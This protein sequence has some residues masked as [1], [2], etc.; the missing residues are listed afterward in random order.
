MG[1]YLA[2]HEPDTIVC[3]EAISS[4][5]DEGGTGQ[6]LHRN[7]KRF[8]LNLL[9]LT[10]FPHYT[11]SLQSPRN[12][13]SSVKNN[14]NV[15]QRSRHGPYIGT[16][17]PRKCRSR[18]VDPVLCIRGTQACSTTG[19]ADGQGSWQQLQLATR[20]RSGWSRWSRCL[21]LHG[22]IRRRQASSACGCCWSCDIGSIESKGIQG[23]CPEGSQAVQP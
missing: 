14:N 3:E 22:R 15:P 6:H 4:T 17:C 19:S 8:N 9:D 5:S 23:V 1:E 16:V 21:V 12:S 18:I 13:R 2:V 20:P 7:R 11:S 10:I